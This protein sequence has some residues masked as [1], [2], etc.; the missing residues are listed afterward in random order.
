MA[1]NTS[2]T[3]PVV[4]KA[5]CID[6]ISDFFYASF[7]F[8]RVILIP[9]EFLWAPFTKFGMLFPCF[10]GKRDLLNPSYFYLTF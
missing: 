5:D 8:I 1:E 2:N 6:F 10:Q 9:V 4:T 3:R 7:I